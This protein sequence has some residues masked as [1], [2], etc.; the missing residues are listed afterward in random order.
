MNKDS[1]DCKRLVEEVIY[2]DVRSLLN[3]NEDKERLIWVINATDLWYL[4]VLV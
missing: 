2:F 3:I 4:L 1:T